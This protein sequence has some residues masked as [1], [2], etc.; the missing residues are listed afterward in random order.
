[1]SGAVCTLVALW[2]SRTLEMPSGDPGNLTIPAA[3]APRNPVGFRGVFVFYCVTAILIL[4][5]HIMKYYV[6]NTDIIQCVLLPEC[7]SPGTRC[8]RRRSLFARK[9]PLPPRR[10]TAAKRPFAPLNADS[11]KKRSSQVACGSA[12]R[13][14]A[15]APGFGKEGDA[16][17]NAQRR[18]S[19]LSVTEQKFGLYDAAFEKAAVVSVSS[20]ART[21]CRHMMCSSAVTRRSVPCRIAV[22]CRPKAWVMV[23]ACRW[24][25]RSPFP[26]ADRRRCP[27]GRAVR[28]RQFFLPQNPAF[29]GE[30]V[31][32]IG[33]A[34]K[35]QG[36]SVLLVRD[37][38][39]NDT[40]IRP[41]AI[42]YQLPIRQWV[43]SAP[44]ECA[45]LAEFDWRI[46]KALL[47]I[48]AL[49]YT[50]PDLAGFTRCRSAR[51]RRSL[52]GV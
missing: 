48:E 32:I 5:R 4:T 42:P 23:R 35:E 44:V 33:N 18:E 43:F 10:L 29:H 39:V 28:R 3:F 49:A 16:A 31:G 8:E 17:R 15:D 46:H 19:A 13:V 37:V 6:S 52:R 41:A 9:R 26:R 50:V 1:M 7:R 2:F 27:T 20:P 21:A 24:T 14:P 12:C 22:A 51:A 45:T 47:A 40:A 34:L 36:F 11:Q 38:P 30:A 25:S